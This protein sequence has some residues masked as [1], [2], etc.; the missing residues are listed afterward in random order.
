MSEWVF[1]VDSSAPVES[2]FLEAVRLAYGTPALWGR[3]L[4]GA[5]TA[6]TALEAELIGGLGVGIVPIVARGP[7]GTPVSQEEIQD[8]YPGGLR[9][10]AAAA[11]LARAVGVPQ[12]TSIVIDVEPGYLPK[13]QDT[14]WLVG[15]S[16]GL[17]QAGYLP[18]LY[19]GEIGDGTPEGGWTLAEA[20]AAIQP[21]NATEAFVAA[22][23]LLWDADWGGANEPPPQDGTVDVLAHAPAPGP[24]SAVCGR[25]FRGNVVIGDFAVDLDVWLIG[26]PDAVVP[27][28]PGPGPDVARAVELLRQALAALGG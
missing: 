24:W 23:P 5:G 8:G 18:V 15:V 10:A 7:S 22:P 26:A 11:T 3:Y 12:G 17:R 2:A 9:T 25:Q 16:D 19:G 21:P 20:L 4:S 14:W 28:R 6:L 13:G 1:G 27:W